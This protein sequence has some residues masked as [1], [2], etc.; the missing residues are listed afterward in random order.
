MEKVIKKREK[1][2]GEPMIGTE[3]NSH[4]TKP[5]GAEMRVLNAVQHSSGPTTQISS[6]CKVQM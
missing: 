1:E 5:R 3:E 2:D 4:T 6:S